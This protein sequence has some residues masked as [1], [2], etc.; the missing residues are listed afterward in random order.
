MDKSHPLLLWQ[1]RVLVRGHIPV[2]TGNPP[3]LLVLLPQELVGGRQL[4]HL[5]LQLLD[6]VHQ[7]R[8]L[9]LQHPHMLRLQK[10]RLLHA[11]VAHKSLL[12]RQ[13][14]PCSR[15]LLEGVLVGLAFGNRLAHAK[16]L[17]RR[18]G[19]LVVPVELPSRRDLLHLRGWIEVAVLGGRWLV[20]SDMPEPATAAAFAFAL[21]EV[22]ADG[23]GWRGL[24]AV[25]PPSTR[26]LVLE[27]VF[28]DE[29]AGSVH[30]LLLLGAVDEAAVG[31][32]ALLVLEVVAEDEFFLAHGLCLVVVRMPEFATGSPVADVAEEVPADVIFHAVPIHTKRVNIL[33]IF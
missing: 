7:P 21:E 13:A 17:E 28:C 5:L 1:V 18:R 4:H 12:G 11:A 3:D 32:A 15:K 25:V 31:P 33:I 26:L 14:V 20:L 22:L 8:I 16:A 29:A 24:A 9:L 2:F 23:D 30:F 19:R 6:L 27:D 10:E